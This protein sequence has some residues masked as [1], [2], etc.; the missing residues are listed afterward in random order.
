MR[1]ADVLN[2]ILENMDSKHSFVRVTYKTYGKQQEYGSFVNS[3]D[4]EELME[5]RMC[6]FCMRNNY[7]NY[8]DTGNVSLT[9]IVTMENI[10]LIQ[11]F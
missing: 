9:K 6:R 8:I 2:S 11:K 3:K 5:K 7:D 1:Q 10:S 4:C